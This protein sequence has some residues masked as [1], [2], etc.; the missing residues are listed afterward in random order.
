MARSFQRGGRTAIMPESASAFWI[1]YRHRE[2]CERQVL[3]PT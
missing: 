3:Y 2:D 1:V